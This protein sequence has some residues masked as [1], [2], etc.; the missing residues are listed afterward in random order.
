MLKPDLTVQYWSIRASG[1][2]VKVVMT[3]CHDIEYYYTGLD[4]FK[5]GDWQSVEGSAMPHTESRIEAE[6]RVYA[7]LDGGWKTILERRES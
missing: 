7:L 3:Y 6:A 2:T 4:V 5:D 1:N